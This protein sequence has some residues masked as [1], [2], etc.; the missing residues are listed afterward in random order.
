MNSKDRIKKYLSLDSIIAWRILA[1]TMLERKKE[2]TLCT[3]IFTEEEWKALYCYANKTREIS[4]E[5]PTLK[6]I[7]MSIAKLGGFLGRKGDG[8]P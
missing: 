6:K 1:I 5:I 8:E 2:G 7:K 3:E 4:K